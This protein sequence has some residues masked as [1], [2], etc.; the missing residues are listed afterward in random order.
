MTGLTTSDTSQ[1]AAYIYAYNG[2][3]L[4]RTLN[5][6]S[7]K[8]LYSKEDILKVDQGETPMYLTQGP[9]IDDVLAETIGTTTNYSYKNMLS[10]V[11][12]L[13]NTTGVVSNYNYDAWGQATN[14]P[15]PASDPNP[16]G[17]TGREWDG[18]GSYYYRA[19]MYTPGVGRFASIDPLTVNGEPYAYA[20]VQNN[21]VRHADP[22][23]M[24]TAGRD[25]LWPNALT[26]SCA[27]RCC[28]IHDWCYFRGGCKWTSW[29]VPSPDCA[30]CNMLVIFCMQGC[31]MGVP[32]AGPDDATD[33]FCA[34]TGKFVKIPG[35]FKDCPTAKQA[36]QSDKP[37]TCSMRPPPTD[38]TVPMPR[39]PIGGW[40]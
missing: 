16:Y 36:C 9:G 29:F 20:Y 14:W 17:Y 24:D 8:Y 19:R 32:P 28:A 4:Q 40:Y 37:P 23:G 21:P 15:A 22:T 26:P 7:W 33:Y 18:A 38:Q 27:R 1:T 13:A 30:V 3:R 11:L 10:S 35:D 31:A 34:A 25:V 6:V 2:D 12:Q 5:N 39:Y